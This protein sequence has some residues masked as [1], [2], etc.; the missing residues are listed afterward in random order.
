MGWFKT[1]TKLH[2]F[3]NKN[4]L[5]WN[6]GHLEAL[7]YLLK[8]N[9]KIDAKDNWEKT[10]L[11]HS[12]IH[13]NLKYL[14]ALF[15]K[16]INWNKLDLYIDHLNITKYLIQKKADINVGD[17]DGHTP[18]HNSAEKGDYEN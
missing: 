5:Y 10:A 2:K 16:S 18:L 17:N 3:E 4:K 11:H 1:L 13:G 8:K 15:Y 12:V 7:Q 6:L 9:A 14:F